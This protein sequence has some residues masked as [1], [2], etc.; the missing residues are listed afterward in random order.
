MKNNQFCQSCSMPLTHELLGTEK[1]GTLSHEYCKFCYSQGEFTN[2]GISMDQMIEHM[3][4]LME[5][6]HLPEDI[7]EAAIARMPH[8]KRWNKHEK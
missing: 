3:S 5:R 4:G 8:L 7:L 1:D 2:P 6:K